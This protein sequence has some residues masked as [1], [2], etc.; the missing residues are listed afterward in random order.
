[1]VGGLGPDDAVLVVAI[2]TVERAGELVAGAVALPARGITYATG[3]VRPVPGDDRPAGSPI[4]LAVS[5]SRPPA[6][7]DALAGHL[8]AKLVP[9]GSARGSR[10]CRSGR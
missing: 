4:R 7:V 8:E 10:R 9:M 1:M 5:R 3:S 6:I 2:A